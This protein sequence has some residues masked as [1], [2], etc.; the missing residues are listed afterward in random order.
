MKNLK[1]EKW[2]VVV[3]DYY[4]SNQGRL[5]RGKGPN[6]RPLKTWKNARGYVCVTIKGKVNTTLGNLVLRTFR[7]QPYQ[8]APVKY[9]D[10][11]RG[12]CRLSN[13]TW[14]T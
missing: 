3:E 6:A 4:V 10:G 8:G 13:L 2:R 9:K 5:R 1:G 11:D 12:N 7:P 14:R